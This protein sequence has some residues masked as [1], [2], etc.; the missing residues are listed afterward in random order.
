MVASQPIRTE[1][2]HLRFLR[3][4]V[5]WQASVAGWLGLLA[6]VTLGDW[7]Q[8]PDGSYEWIKALLFFASIPLIQWWIRRRVAKL[9]WF[10]PRLGP[11]GDIVYGGDDS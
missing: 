7:F 9:E 5:G 10:L 3:W 6:G 8:R 2:W 4:F 1:I 11:K